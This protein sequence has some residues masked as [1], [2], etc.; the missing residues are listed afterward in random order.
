VG[1]AVAL[2]LASG[3]R[4]AEADDG[5]FSAGV[6]A[7]YSAPAGDLETGSHVADVAF[8]LVPFAVRL[9][10]AL[11]RRLVVGFV[12]GYAVGIPT[13]CATASDCVASLGRDVTLGARA[14]YIVTRV[15]R[16]EPRFEVGFGYEWLRTTLSNNG[17]SSSRSYAGPVVAALNVFAPFRLSPR[18]LLGPS[19]GAS[20]GIF[21][22]A[23]LDTPAFSASGDVV[24]RR[25]HAWLTPTVRAALE[26]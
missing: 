2:V 1:W 20:L 16:F 26:F 23:E 12:V 18:L 21:T 13:L 15:G 5:R 10:Y 4:S 24:A 3:S 7:G 19:I 17:V 8:G 22:S 9:G 6:E 14:E 11:T 25:L